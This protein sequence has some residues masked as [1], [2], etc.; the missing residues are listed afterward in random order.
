MRVLHVVVLGGPDAI[1][2]GPTT[3]ALNQVEELRARGHQV[4]LVA[5]WLGPEPP[6]SLRG[7]Q[8]EMVETRSLWPSYRFS[9]AYSA[10]LDERLRQAV[11]GADLVHV[12]F[13][14]DLVSLRATFLASRNGI[15][16]VLQT[17]GMVVPDAR[18]LVRALDASLVRRALNGATQ[19]LALGEEERGHLASMGVSKST[20][21]PNGLGL[22]DTTAVPRD[23]GEVLFLALLK[24]TKRPLLFVQAARILIQRGCPYRFTLVGPD[25]GELQRVLSF[26]QENRLSSQVTYEGPVEPG[27]VVNRMSRAAVYVLPSSYEPFGMTILESLQAGTPAIITRECALAASLSQH[28]CAYVSEASPGQLANSIHS[29]ISNHDLQ[30]RLAK[31]GRRYVEREFSIERTVDDLELIYAAAREGSDP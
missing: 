14:R 17:H 9:T 3:V 15:P 19:V 20:V 1:F 12:H 2:G 31:N 13:G 5:G 21:M 6:D 10:A 24:P 7:I 4:R 29:V 18:P 30:R 22:R 16:Y 11:K 8:A 23:D 28:E 27:D 25:N 26:I